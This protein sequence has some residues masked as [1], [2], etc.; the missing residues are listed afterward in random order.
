M[1]DHYINNLIFKV[2]ECTWLS[3]T[4]SNLIGAK[5][6]DCAQSILRRRR[7]RRPSSHSLRAHKKL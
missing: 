5:H 2:N 1:C 6:I 4:T 7:R 3:S